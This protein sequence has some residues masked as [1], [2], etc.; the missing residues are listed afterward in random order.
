MKKRLYISEKEKSETIINPYL[1]EQLLID[2]LPKI[3]KTERNIL[4]T[5]FG[6]AQIARA[7]TLQYPFS[8][9][10]CH[11]FDIFRA[12]LAREFITDPS[13]RLLIGCSADFPEEKLCL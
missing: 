13:E 6:R 3:K 2:F 11:Y 5:S 7:F 8:R 1:Q 4:C 12:Q 9:V 10:Y